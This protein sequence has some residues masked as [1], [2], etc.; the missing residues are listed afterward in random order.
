MIELALKHSDVARV[1]FA[2]SPVAQLM[3]SLR[4]LQDRSRHHMYRRWLAAVAGRLDGVRMDLL[5]ALEPAGPYVPDFLAPAPV[6]ADRALADELA[7]V[8]ETDPSIVRRE[9]DQLFN[10]R[11]VP[12]VL[13]PLYEDPA[14]HLPRVVEEMDRYWR[15]AIE[16]VWPRIRALALADVAFRLEQFAFG[17]VSLLLSELNHE[18]R[19]EAERIVIRRSVNVRA[20]LG[21]RGLV[22]VPSAFV[23]PGVMVTAS[24]EYQGLVYYPVRGLA[25]IYEGPPQGQ[26]HSLNALVGRT[27]ATLLATLRLPL[28]TTEL[29]A[30][31][32]MSPAAVSQHLKIL[33]GAELVA[34]RRQG[35]AVLYQ[36]TTV[37]TTLLGIPADQ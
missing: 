12:P 25:D 20:K 27:R 24:D 10:R 23:W 30:H 36:R 29:A 1:R 35:R 3:P 31:L 7:T 14:R 34:S 11:P 9:L 22:L 13:R 6:G 16:P 28:T 2:Q 15:V 4:V 8:A 19:F 32:D 37:G 33:K 18:L 26:A 21:G 17:G 5:T